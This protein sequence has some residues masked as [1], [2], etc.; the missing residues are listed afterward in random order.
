MFL[1]QIFL[2]DQTSLELVIHLKNGSDCLFID[3]EIHTSNSFFNANS[4]NGAR[5]FLSK[6]ICL[7][8]YRDYCNRSHSMMNQVAKRLPGQAPV[9]EIGG[10]SK[11]L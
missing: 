11:N 6:G 8:R 9:I 1:V 3:D 7:R 2:F 4:K 10:L 5:R